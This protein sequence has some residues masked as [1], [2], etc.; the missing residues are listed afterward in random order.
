M[1]ADFFVNTSFSLFRTILGDFDFPSLQQ[2]NSVLGP[3]FFVLYVF[4]VF[5]ILLN[6]FLAIINDT[7]G[8]VKSDLA[9]QQN[10]FEMGEYFKKV[11]DNM[12]CLFVTL[13]FSGCL[14]LDVQ[15]WNTVAIRTINSD[16]CNLFSKLQTVKSDIF[17]KRFTEARIVKS[18]FRAMNSYFVTLFRVPSKYLKE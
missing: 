1:T 8:E 12:N 2:A 3:M 7:Y 17:I 11:C 10:E 18:N 6:M 5:F 15:C 13:Y 9:A 16:Y 4:F 14:D